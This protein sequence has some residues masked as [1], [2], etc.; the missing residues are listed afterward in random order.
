MQTTEA[1]SY[2]LTPILGLVEDAASRSIIGLFDFVVGGLTG[3]AMLAAITMGMI[4]PGAARTAQ[5][6]IRPVA[7]ADCPVADLLC[8]EAPAGTRPGF[9]VGG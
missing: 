5:A 6:Q 1:M 7:E 8:A 2:E 3:A 9:S 4:E